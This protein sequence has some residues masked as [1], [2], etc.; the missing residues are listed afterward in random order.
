L[1][2]GLG[3]LGASFLSEGVSRF[4]MTHQHN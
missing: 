2:L 1:S 4:L 3:N